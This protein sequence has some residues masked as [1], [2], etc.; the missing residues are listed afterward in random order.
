MR[1]HDYYLALL[2]PCAE[3]IGLRDLFC[4]EEIFVATLLENAS[5][6]DSNHYSL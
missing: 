5:I 6:S 1:L 4:E 2:K 3:L